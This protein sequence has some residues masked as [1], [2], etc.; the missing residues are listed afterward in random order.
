LFSPDPTSL[1]IQPV[2]VPPEGRSRVVIDR[3]AG[4]AGGRKAVR[5]ETAVEGET[6]LVS[7]V[8]A[9]RT[10]DALAYGKNRVVLA[11]VDGVKQAEAKSR[12]NRV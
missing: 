4:S 5:R 10:L 3:G 12:S 11:S 8:R 7:D 9:C 6:E 2:F 1:L